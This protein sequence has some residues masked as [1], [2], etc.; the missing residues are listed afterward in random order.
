MQAQPFK[1]TALYVR[2]TS[3]RGRGVFT[4]TNLKADTLL[5]VAPVIVMSGKERLL[6]DQTR[7]HDYIFEWGERRERCAMALGWIPLFNHKAPANCDYEMDF[8]K[9]IMRIKTVVAVKAEEEL[10]INYHGD[11]TNTKPVWFA[12]KN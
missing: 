11:P 5:E 4:K 10:F 2:S 9:D 8:K 1:H 12:T 3:S 6:L 7:L